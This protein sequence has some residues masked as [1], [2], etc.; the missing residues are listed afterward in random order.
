MEI[1]VVWGVG[2]AL[3]G[4]VAACLLRRSGSIRGIALASTLAVATLAVNTN[5]P[6]EARSIGLAFMVL[7]LIVGFV[8]PRQNFRRHKIRLLV[9]AW[10]GLFLLATSIANPD[11][12]TALLHLSVL[13]TMTVIVG[14]KMGPQD[15]EAFVAGLVF[16]GAAHSLLSVGEFLGQEPWLWGYGKT[17][18]G[19]DFILANPFLGGDFPRA[20]STMGHPIP[21]ATLVAA[22]LLTLLHFRR[23]YRPVMFGA[24]LFILAVGIL[25][26]GTR[27]VVVGIA[28]ALAFYYLVSSESKFKAVRRL[29]ATVI[30]ATFLAVILGASTLVEQLV[31]SGS[32]TNRAGALESVPMLFAREPGAVIWGSGFGSEASLFREGFF[33]QNGFNIVDN[34][35][36]TTLGTAGVLGLLGLCA[37]FIY[38]FSTAGIYGRTALIFM[39]VMLFSFDYLRWH[40]TAVL[41]FAIMGMSSSMKPKHRDP[42]LEAGNG[43]NHSADFRESGNQGP[44]GA[45]TDPRGESALN[46]VF[47]AFGWYQGSISNRNVMQEMIREWRSRFPQD[48]VH[49]VTHRRAQESVAAELGLPAEQVHTVKIKQ[50]GLSVLLEYPGILRRLN[51]EHVLAHNFVP[52]FTRRASAFVHD[53][54]FVS[55]PQW[56]AMYFWLLKTSL[57][58]SS[59]LFSSRHTE[60]ARIESLCG[61]G[62]HVHTTGPAVSTGLAAAVPRMP[63]LE[64]SEYGYFLIV[65]RPN[66]RDDLALGLQALS[67]SG[68]ISP[69]NPAVVVSEKRF[70]SSE[71]PPEVTSMVETGAI[72]FVGFM[73]QEELAWLY[74]KAKLV[75]F[76]ALDEGYGLPVVEARYFGAPLALSDIPVLREVAGDAEAIFFSLQDKARAAAALAAAPMRTSPSGDAKSRNSVMAQYSW[77]R[78]VETIR[79]CT[80]GDVANS[81]R[82]GAS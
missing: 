23:S 6:R 59:Q 28:L 33:Q 35:L 26:T 61:R 78:T 72:R 63:A 81:K 32:Y 42:V 48:E 55:S 82:L 3:L 71:L 45:T 13:A 34:Q 5:V 39:T 20:Q 68:V 43:R 11:G 15:R 73:E 1:Y 53:P 58:N 8:A 75:V 50:H 54:I 41:L 37:I 24:L 18:D 65:G 27:S 30:V 67:A 60:A 47:D 70:K 49:I 36:V 69:V 64:L 40:A 7:F 9:F 62:G 2:L 46:I 12:A 16:L 10:F 17:P 44:A 80:L 77:K 19:T 29:T 56:F 66:E 14:S 74:S 52:L 51:A 25:L 76:P 79:D 38:S 21:A 22:S 31:G 4:W 57:K